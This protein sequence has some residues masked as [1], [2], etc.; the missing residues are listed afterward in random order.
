MMIVGRT[1][2]IDRAFVTYLRYRR[3]EINQTTKR[4]IIE[5]VISAVM[6]DAALHNE[7]YSRHCALRIASQAA[8]GF[9]NNWGTKYGEPRKLFELCSLPLLRDDIHHRRPVVAFCDPGAANQTS[10]LL[11]YLLTYL[12]RG[13][14]Q[15]TAYNG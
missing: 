1:A 4:R 2:W 3:R 14:N 13:I 6:I 5:R 10:D 8:P 9:W 7:S 12:L 11:T 15:Q